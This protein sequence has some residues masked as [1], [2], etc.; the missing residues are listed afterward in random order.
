MVKR[1]RKNCRPTRAGVK[2]TDFRVKRFITYFEN[3]TLK[4]HVKRL[5]EKFCAQRLKGSFAEMYPCCSVDSVEISHIRFWFSYY[6]PKRYSRPSKS[7]LS[8]C[9]IIYV[10]LSSSAV[11]IQYTS[12]GTDHP[13]AFYESRVAFGSISHLSPSTRLSPGIWTVRHQEHVPISFLRLFHAADNGLCETTRVWYRTRTVVTTAR[14]PRE[15]FGKPTFGPMADTKHTQ[16]R[17]SWW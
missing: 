5:E 1:H 14:R 3:S 9:C 2:C 17:E 6:G 4:S 8:R 12:S 16:A 13:R 15:S 7:Y 11:S 10:H